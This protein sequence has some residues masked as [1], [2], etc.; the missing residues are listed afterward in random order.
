MGN[1]L[2]SCLTIFLFSF[3][4]SCSTG[5]L[6]SKKT[7]HQQYEVE[8]KKDKLRE[9]PEGRAWMAASSTALNNPQVVPVPYIQKGVFKTDKPRALG[10]SFVATKGQKLTFDLSQDRETA[11]AIYADVYLQKDST[12]R[13]LVFSADTMT[14]QFAYTVEEN[15]VY[16]L[17]LQPELNQGGEYTLSIVA[18]PSIGFPVSGKV[19][20]IGSFWGAERDAGKRMHEGIDIFAPRGTPAIAATDG[21]I[22]AV[23]TGGIG[24]KTVWLRAADP[25]VHIYYAHLDQQLVSEGQSVRTGD[26]LGLIGNTGNAIRTPPHLHFGLYGYG[27]AIDPYPYVNRQVE[28]PRALKE[29]S[30]PGLLKFKKSL[31]KSNK[32]GS[33]ADSVLVPL[34]VNRNG[35][36]CELPSGKII[37]APFKKVRAVADTSLISSRN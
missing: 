17:R 22:D 1:H 6:F 5:G 14:R 31:K 34:A 15:G 10:L 11:M 4:I 16:L 19:G 25:R 33:V 21:I 24:G 3:Y 28:K 20:K 9:T 7:P 23:R 29:I 37:Q 2:Y 27:G 13:S 26:T 8:L 12:D 30:I 18:G 36:I 32:I 35:Y